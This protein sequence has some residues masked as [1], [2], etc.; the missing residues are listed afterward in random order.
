VNGALQQRLRFIDIVLQHYGWLRRQVLMDQ[1]GISTQQ[2]SMDIQVY[3]DVAQGNMEYDN[4]AKLYR[5]CEGFT[6]RIA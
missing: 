3:L 6:R 4:N 1:F 2:A 5:R